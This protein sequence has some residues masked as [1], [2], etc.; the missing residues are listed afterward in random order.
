M[1]GKQYS[2]SYVIFAF[3]LVMVASYFGNSFRNNIIDGETKDDYELV[4]KYL[5]NDSAMYG[6][7]R[8]KIWIHSK[9]EVNARKWKNFM[10]RNTTDLNQPYLYLTV[11]S[12]INHCGDDFHICLIDDDSFEKLIPSW[13]IDMKQIPEP[14]KSRYRDIAMVQLLYIYGGMVVPNSFLCT[15][16]LVDIYKQGIAQKTPFI[17]EKRMYTSEKTKLFMP[18]IQFMGGQKED[19]KLEELI[20]HAN[21][22]LGSHF[23]NENEFESKIEKWCMEQVDN[24]NMQS[25]DGCIIG[26]KTKIGKPILVEDLM[27]D[28]FLDTDPSLLHGIYI[29]KNELLRRPKFQY[30][31]ILPHEPVLESSNILSK[32]FKMSMVDGVDEYYKK[33]SSITSIIGI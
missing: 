13:T 21:S 5:L 2:M 26:I 6:K 4:K 10:S 9:Y 11:Q 30:Y 7:N 31:T 16:P 27:S 1:F 29:P 18:D 17:A 19:K 25:I 32:Y 23:Q 20:Q 8:P 22:L 15:K 12:I 33:K 3:G 28:N 24:Q 14:L